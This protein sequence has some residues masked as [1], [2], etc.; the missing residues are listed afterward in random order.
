[1]KGE[2]VVCGTGIVGMVAALAFTRAGERVTLLGPAPVIAPADPQHYQA[3]V[4]AIS[5]ASQRFLD[6]LGV[7]AA[8]PAAR[9]TP[10]TSMEIHGDA[11]GS[12]TLDAWQA[13][14]SQLTWIVESAELERVL[15]QAAQWSG[16]TWVQDRYAGREANT[17]LTAGGRRLAADLLV[18]ADGSASPVRRDAGLTQHSRPY[19][20]TGLV[21]HFDVTRAHRQTAA[22]WFDSDGVLGI[23]P[24]PDTARG[25]QVSMVWSVRTPV[26]DAL[27][28][29]PAEVQA[30]RL[31]R[32]LA[33]LTRGRFGALTM[34]SRLHGFPLYVEHADP[35]APGVALVG[36][37]AHRVHPMAGQG[38]NLGLGDVEA[39]SEILATREPFRGPGDLRVLGRYRRVRAEP[40]LAMRYLTDSLHRLFFSTQHPV[41]AHLRNAGMRWV[42]AAPP[43]KRLL[44]RGAAGH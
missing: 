1:M 25:P 32:T 12:F 19:G 34:N 30:D 27:L 21:A 5:E 24:L 29:E 13:A 31:A 39:L 44:V 20:D 16:L 33:V 14:Q 9:I 11:D 18:G 35:I 42:D 43:L 7:W 38:L 4:Y 2:I 22:Q 36:D 6:R 28:A 37:A 23:L 8:L 26:A 17:V 3:R 41:V 15:A 10:V 40:V